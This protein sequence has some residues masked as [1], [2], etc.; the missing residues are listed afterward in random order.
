LLGPSEQ[1]WN[2]S[3]VW[4][5][6]LGAIQSVTE[7]AGNI[8]QLFESP[9]TQVAKQTDVPSES[10]ETAEADT[11]PPVAASAGGGVFLLFVAVL[12]VLLFRR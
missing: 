4:G 3:S 2:G 12:A 1:P 9:E 10:R 11:P 8:A 5:G 6:L 7:S